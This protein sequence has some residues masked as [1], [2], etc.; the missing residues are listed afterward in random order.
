MA[1]QHLV[2][3]IISHPLLMVMHANDGAFY[4]GWPNQ[5]PDLKNLYPT[6]LLETGWDILFFWIAR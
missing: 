3:G 2:S 5:T 6:S 1:L 4:R